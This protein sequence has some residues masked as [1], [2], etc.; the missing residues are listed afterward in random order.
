MAAFTAGLFTMSS[1]LPSPVTSFGIWTSWGFIVLIAS[2]LTGRIW[3]RPGPPPPPPA[4]RVGLVKE[5]EVPGQR[6]TAHRLVAS[7]PGNPRS[8]RFLLSPARKQ[9][10]LTLRAPQLGGSQTSSSRGRRNV[11]LAQ[12]VQPPRKKI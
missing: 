2:R 4:W 3:M 5:K 10:V 7:W 11:R 8:F 6:G 1:Q 12:K 9:Y